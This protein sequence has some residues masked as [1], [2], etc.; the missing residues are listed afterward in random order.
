MSKKFN[1]GEWVDSS[2]LLCTY[3]DE[4]QLLKFKE[5]IGSREECGC[6]NCR[7]YFNVMNSLEIFK[8]E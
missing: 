7:G 8:Y 4:E 3:C 1:I 6:D 2:Y 5:C